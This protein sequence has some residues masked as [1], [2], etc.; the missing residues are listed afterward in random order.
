[1]MNFDLDRVSYV[2]LYIGQMLFPLI[3]LTLIEEHLNRQIFPGIESL[4]YLSWAGPGEGAEACLLGLGQ[5]DVRN[6]FTSLRMYLFDIP[7]QQDL[8]CYGLT[9]E[10]LS[11][12][13]HTF[14]WFPLKLQAFYSFSLVWAFQYRCSIITIHQRT[15]RDDT[16]F[17]VIGMPHRSFTFN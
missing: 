6:Q 2:Q 16:L 12:W 4:W 15:T 3:K 5:L 9:W 14:R 10:R 11:V 7:L 1:M 17:K 13:V 8:F